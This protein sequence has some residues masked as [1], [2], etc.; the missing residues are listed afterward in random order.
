[1]TVL[2]RLPEKLLKT[3]GESFMHSSLLREMLWNVREFR[4]YIA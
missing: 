1:M 3:D 2:V 4:H